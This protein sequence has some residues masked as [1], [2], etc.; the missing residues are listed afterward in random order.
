[1]AGDLADAVQADD[2]GV[3]KPGD[4]ARFNQEPLAGGRNARKSG[5]ELERDR[6]VK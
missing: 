1:M 3:L 5:Q 6:A 2:V 4:G